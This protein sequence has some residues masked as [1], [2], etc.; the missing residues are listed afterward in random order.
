MTVYTFSTLKPTSL[1]D[2]FYWGF[3]YWV[4]FIK[5]WF[6][7]DKWWKKI[8][9]DWGCENL[10][11]DSFLSQRCQC[12]KTMQW[13]FAPVTTVSGVIFVRPYW[14][15]RSVQTLHLS[16]GRQSQVWPMIVNFDSYCKNI[17][18]LWSICMSFTSKIFIYSGSCSINEFFLRNF[19]RYVTKGKSQVHALVF[20]VRHC[21]TGKAL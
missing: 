18:C 15:S 6:I 19:L 10:N 1:L 8:L 21:V 12:Y 16:D 3:T 7:V 20:D 11:I 4:H 9:W 2:F 5:I 17:W 14:S 13:P